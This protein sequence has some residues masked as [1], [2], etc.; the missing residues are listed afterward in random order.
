MNTWS[1]IDASGRKLRI[2]F[3]GWGAI[4]RRAGG[5]LAARSD[6]V[7]IVGVGTRHPPQD[8]QSFPKDA[9]WLAK[10]EDLVDLAPDLV[11]EAAG[12]A[13]VEPWGLVGLRCS[14]AFV[15]SS[16]S[17]FTEDDV[18]QRLIDEANRNGSQILIPPGALGGLDALG[19][20]GR[21]ALRSVVHRIIKPPRAW[22]GTPA[23]G[24]VDLKALDQAKTFFRGSAREAA[25]LFPANANVA[26]ISALA[27]VGFDRTV[28]E[29]IADPGTELN[30]HHLLAEGDF[31][32]LNMRVEN[33]PL[34][35]NPKSSEL[36]A[37][38]LVRLIEGR[39][40]PLSL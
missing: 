16:T 22:M 30:C 33:R 8:D 20:A 7:S 35:D 39:I 2:A 10:P 23:E 40:L 36:T 24:L 11:V 34:A 13:A 29:L 19:A 18:L 32:S 17:A 27:G 15:V 31:G 1:A 12:R 28:V 25:Q 26:V 37:L 4:A 5:L 14:P 6:R 38:S 9:R 21:L 3:V